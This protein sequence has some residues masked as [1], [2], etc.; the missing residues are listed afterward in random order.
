MA[1]TARLLKALVS[2][3][4]ALE[5]WQREHRGEDGECPTAVETFPDEWSPPRSLKT[6]QFKKIATEDPR[7]NELPDGVV[8]YDGEDPGYS[9]AVNMWNRKQ[10]Y[11]VPYR[12]FPGPAG[13]EL[14]LEIKELLVLLRETVPPEYFRRFAR[15]VERVSVRV[16]KDRRGANVPMKQINGKGGCT[17]GKG[18]GR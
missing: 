13:I 5:E 10:Q 6:G 15:G 2:D 11:T 17:C 7:G 4:A 9:V 18:A 14:A 3:P 1:S 16:A 8:W 12:Y